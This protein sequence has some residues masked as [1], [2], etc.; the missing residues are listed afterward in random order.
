MHL[1]KM[2]NV[3]CASFCNVS[4]ESC[5]SSY[6]LGMESGAISDY[7]ITASDYYRDS[8]SAHVPHKARLNNGDI[9]GEGSMFGLKSL[10]CGVSW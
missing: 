9:T 7:Q 10:A 3:E 1:T 5:V 4:A 2:A 6:A 8:S